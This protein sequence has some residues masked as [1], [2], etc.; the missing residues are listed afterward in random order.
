VDA[1]FLLE[2][3]QIHAIGFVRS[4]DTSKFKTFNK[5]LQE[6]FD[7]HDTTFEEGSALH[8]KIMDIVDMILPLKGHKYPR[9]SV[10]TVCYTTMSME[11]MKC[12]LENGSTK[13]MKFQTALKKINV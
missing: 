6:V 11:F 1:L 12:L 2:H 13:H 3:V 4:Q 8:S 9:F 10:I 7:V 5:F